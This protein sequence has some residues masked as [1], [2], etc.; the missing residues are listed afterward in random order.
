MLGKK[1]VQYASRRAI[2]GFKKL[3]VALVFVASSATAAPSFDCAV[4]PKDDLRITPEFVEVADSNG[5]LVIYPDG[6]LLR[7]EKSVTLTPEQQAIAKKYQATVRQD[8]PWLRKETGIK[9]QESRK[10]LDKVVIE[11]FGQDS[12]I[13]KRLS[14]LEKNLNQQMDTVISLKPD[15][16]TFHAQA[17]K[18]VETKGREIIESSLGGM[19]Q[20]S[21]NELGQKQLLA[22]ASGDR[23]KALSGLLGNLDGFQQIIEKEWKQQEASFNQFGKQACN[24]ITQMEN[25]R[26]ELMNS[27]NK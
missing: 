27:L 3:V 18:Q 22:A 14:D 6:T 5:L 11:A 21:I 24:K 13:L 17:I 8:I 4:T 12:R 23:K 16:V 19:L 2:M 1:V 9:L 10:V 15:N 20:D 25:Q 26:V 7:D